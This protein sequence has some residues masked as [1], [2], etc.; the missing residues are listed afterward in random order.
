MS[1]KIPFLQMFAALRRWTELSNAVEGWLILS[2]AIDKA[3]RSAKILVEGAQGAGP[4]LIRETEETLC[5]ASGFN[6]VKLVLSE[7]CKTAHTPKQPAPQPSVPWVQER[8]EEKKREPQAAPPANAFDRAEAL[9]QAAMKNIARPAQPKS[10]GKKESGSAIFGKVIKKMPTPIGELELDMG[11][12]VVE[13]DVFAVDNK[14]LK[15]RGAWVVAFD[16]T[17]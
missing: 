10:D 2:A 1:Q 4:N 16:M 7:Q 14:E 17:D 15:K 6:S 11:M 3:S 5:R 12:V 9:R 8:E 13:G